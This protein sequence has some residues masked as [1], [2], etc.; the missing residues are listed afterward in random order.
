MKNNNLIISCD[1]CYGEGSLSSCCAGGVHD[2]KCDICGKFCKKEMCF[3]CEGRGLIEYNINDD[4]EIF[5]CAFSSESLKDQINYYPKNIDQIKTFKGKIIEI[6]NNK[7]IKVYIK[8]YKKEIIIDPNEV[9]L[10]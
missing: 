6:I 1:E 10:T 7:K 5:V 3:Q 9:N 4:V 8:Y 2:G